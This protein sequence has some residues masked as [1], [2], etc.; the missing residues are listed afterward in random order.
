MK[1]VFTAVLLLAL[2][3]SVR[4]Q[5]AYQIDPAHTSARFSVKHMTV[6]EVHGRLDTLSG[7]AHYESTNT[8]VADQIS[9]ELDAEL[10]RPGAKAAK[11]E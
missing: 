5:N 3:N 4:A 1:R 10:V 11:S 8:V 2:A 7:T 6:S 9:I